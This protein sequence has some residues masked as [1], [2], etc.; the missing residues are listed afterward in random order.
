M[1][2]NE[3]VD[4]LEKTLG[5]NEIAFARKSGGGADVDHVVVEL[6]GERKL[7]TTVL[8]T[9]SEH[10]VRVEAFV[11]R[12]P[13]EN[14]AGVYKY[15]LKRNRRLYGV[16]Y[17]IDNTGD[18]YLVGRI[19]ADGLSSGEVDRILGQVLEAADGDFN[20]LLE[21]GFLTSIQREW[22]WR[23]SRG[24]SLRNLLAF[25]HLIDKESLPEAGKPLEGRYVPGESVVDGAQSVTEDP[26][27]AES[28]E[29]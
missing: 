27:T 9:A 10:G 8:L 5:E 14:H 12:R 15:L 21:L 29:S 2:R 4:L 19:S 18:I 25:E 6:P 23:V 20:T 24:E 17:T 26:S 3:V 16:A 28:D 7:K 1:S 13:D 22:A 11:C